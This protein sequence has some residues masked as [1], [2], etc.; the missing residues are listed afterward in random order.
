MLSFCLIS[1]FFMWYLNF[2]D[3]HDLT[4]I[5]IVM[6]RIFFVMFSFCL[7]SV[8][9]IYV[10]F[11]WYLN[12]SDTHDFTYM[13]IVISSFFFIML[14]FCSSFVF[15]LWYLN[16]LDTQ[17]LIGIIKMRLLWWFGQFCQTFV[18]SWISENFRYHRKQT[19]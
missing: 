17:D 10:L 9:L 4:Y 5:S 2:S 6:S 13:S 3:T 18:E 12:F 11:M 16:F 1:V 7:S 19:C 8:W 14:S 15:F